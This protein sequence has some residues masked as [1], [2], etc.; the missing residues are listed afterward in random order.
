MT[1]RPDG[2]PAK[3]RF[4]VI[5]QA[6]GVSLLR[7]GLETGRTH[8]VRVHFKH[9]GHPLVGDPVYGE[10]RWKAI[11]GAARKSLEQFPRP[12]LHA[13]RLRLLHPGDG[14][15]IDFVSQPPADMLLLWDSV[16][17]GDLLAA[18]DQ[19]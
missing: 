10:A 18:L 11:R 7:V 9:V 17:G 6:E 14:E 1:V 16:A 2:R 4:E 12:A 19:S 13:W 3:T 8:Q 15:E 5:A